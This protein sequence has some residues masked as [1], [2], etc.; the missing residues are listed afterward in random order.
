MAEEC[1]AISPAILQA[2]YGQG[3]SS[4]LL[5]NFRSP[6]TLFP[7][8]PLMRSWIASLVFCG[9]S[10]GK[11]SFLCMA[12]ARLWQLLLKIG[13][14]LGKISCLKQPEAGLISIGASDWWRW[15][16]CRN[17][18]AANVP[19][20]LGDIG[21]PGLKASKAFLE[22]VLSNDLH[23]WNGYSRVI[24]ENSSKTGNKK[25]V[26]ISKEGWT[27]QWVD[28]LWADTVENSITWWAPW[29]YV[30]REEEVGCAGER[31]KLLRQL[32]TPYL[33]SAYIF[34]SCCVFALFQRASLCW[35]WPHRLRVLP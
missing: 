14:L 25:S 17:F 7:D 4:S 32:S 28:S 21:G 20:P 29:M 18:T 9:N 26:L 5:L 12:L 15:E 3:T 1:A 16:S 31:R 27:K 19:A 6:N 22:F 30:Q 10:S 33:S 13:L 34:E 8:L 24:P 23:L 35:I 11:L 2:A